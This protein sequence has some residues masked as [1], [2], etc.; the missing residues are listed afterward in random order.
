MVIL[1]SLEL[2]VNNQVNEKEESLTSPFKVNKARL[3]NRE[4]I[5]SSVN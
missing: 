2:L 5:F 3:E 1:S 4:V